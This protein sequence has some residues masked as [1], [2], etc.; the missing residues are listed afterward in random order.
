MAVFQGRF[1]DLLGFSTVECVLSCTTTDED[2]SRDDGRVL[3][4]E[5]DGEKCRGG[6]ARVVTSTTRELRELSDDS[7][8]F[9]VK[10]DGTVVGEHEEVTVGV[11]PNKWV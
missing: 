4:V 1:V 11:E 9:R 10:K 3:D 7:I 8:C 2:I 6:G 5:A